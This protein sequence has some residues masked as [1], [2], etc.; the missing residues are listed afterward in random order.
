MFN[1]EDQSM[2]LL[3]TAAG[4]YPDGRVFS[5][6]GLTPDRFIEDKNADLIHTAAVYLT[7]Q[8]KTQ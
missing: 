4:H 7:Q 8:K 3:V 1:L 5:F 6:K 2:L